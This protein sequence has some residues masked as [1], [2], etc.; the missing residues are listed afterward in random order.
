VPECDETLRQEGGV[1]NVI[2]KLGTDL[3]NAS[4]TE[5]R[6]FTLENCAAVVR[7]GLGWQADCVSGA[8]RNEQLSFFG[9]APRPEL[10]DAV[11][12]ALAVSLIVAPW[13]L[14]GWL[15]WMLM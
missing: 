2:V 5:G 15:I 6:N 9:E 7:F 1:R 14:I 12:A 4:R 13:L 11:G 3:R 10:P 8:G